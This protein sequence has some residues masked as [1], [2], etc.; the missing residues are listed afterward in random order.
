MKRLAIGTVLLVVVVVLGVFLVKWWLHVDVDGKPPLADKP[1]VLPATSSHLALAVDCPRAALVSQLESAITN[2]LRFDVN[3]DGLRVYDK[4]DVSRGSINV[5]I[6]VP[7]K[8]VTFATTVSGH[9]QVEKR[10]KIDLLVTHIDKL[11]SVGVNGTVRCSASLSPVVDTNWNIDPKLNFSAHVDRAIIRMID[12][13]HI[14]HVDVDIAGHLQA[15]VADALN[16]AKAMAEIKLKK[17][18]EVRP[19]VEPL[20]NQ[21]NSVHELTKTPPTWLRIIP[22]KALFGGFQ[23]TPDAIKSGLALDLNTEVFVRGDAPPIAKKPLSSLKVNAPLS[24]EFNLEIPVKV[25]YEAINEQLKA[26]LAKNPIKNPISLGESA[27][28]EISNL[29][30]GPSGDGIMLTLDFSASKG[31]FPSLG[32]F[33]SA[34]GHLYVEGIPVFNAEKSELSVDKLQFSVGTKNILVKSADWLFHDKILEEAKHAAVVNLEGELKRATEQA[35][36]YLNELKRQ[37]PN[38]VG[39][40]AS[41]KKIRIKGLGFAKDEAFTLIEATGNMSVQLKP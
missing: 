39:A 16:K 10:I 12:I 29:S 15:G 14:G 33:L 4:G 38:G 41:V 37:L 9:V 36:Q 18:L 40:N 21:M 35:N 32:W 13:P 11:A 28:I 27:S 22:Q 26:T 19:N 25:S 1:F 23:Y 31:K 8:R 3:K 6:D 24:G 2:P 5:S 20:W 34:S 17:V 7:N 30:I